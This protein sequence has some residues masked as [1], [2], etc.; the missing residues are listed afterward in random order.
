M[1]SSNAPH[2]GVRQVAQLAGVSVATV[3]RVFNG[4]PR[5]SESARDKVLAAARQLNYVPNSA[6]RALTLSRTFT[7]G[8]IVPTL[9][10]SIFARFLQSLEERLASQGY[11]MVVAACGGDPVLEAQRADGLLKMGAEA[12]VLSGA[13]HQARLID[14]L[15]ARGVPYVF[16]S[17]Y[18]PDQ[19][20]PAIGYD[21]S[22][23]GH[24][25]AQYLTDLGHRKIAVLSGETANN[26]RTALRVSG[27]MAA[28]RERGLDESQISHHVM[29]LSIS[30][31]CRVSRDIAT[32]TGDR[33]TAL[34][35]L[36]D[37]LALGALLELPKHGIRVP[38]DISVI[39]FDDLEWADCTNPPL[40][41]IHLPT[42][43]MGQEIALAIL[44]A[45]DHGI[46]IEPRLLEAE[47]VV[48]SSTA[49]PR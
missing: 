44:D 42:R 18:S 2:A 40:T 34:L 5:V 13:S 38:A 17:I 29:P 27:A 22:R 28:L 12:L 31:A 39:G 4:A 14:L 20:E 15:Q 32:Q 25:A 37:V 23:L 43:R 33:P 45:L 8:V 6:A 26:D 30:H 21:N 47:L 3:S 35:C 24:L 7:V 36:S 41:T 16:N 48:R 49:A 1:K 46:P 19:T 9:E 11:S 10:H